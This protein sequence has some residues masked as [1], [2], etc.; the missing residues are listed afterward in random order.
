MTREIKKK[1]SL[2]I[3]SNPSYFSGDIKMKIDLGS[4]SFSLTE[5]THCGKLVASGDFELNNGLSY[6]DFRKYYI[7]GEDCS[8]FS[9][10]W[11]VT[12]KAICVDENM[13]QGK[14]KKCV[15]ILYT[16]GYCNIVL[17]KPMSYIGKWKEDIPVLDV[18]AISTLK[19]KEKFYYRVR[20]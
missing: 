11:W 17:K 13:G 2:A 18:V 16:E 19:W 4:Y 1:N 7:D 12:D 6:S 3:D 9:M 14:E 8:R 15:A 20:N 5:A 10:G